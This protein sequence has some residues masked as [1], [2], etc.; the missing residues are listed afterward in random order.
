MRSGTVGVSESKHTPTTM[1][2]TNWNWT[3]TCEHCK[4][5][6]CQSENEHGADGM[7]LIKNVFENSTSQWKTSKRIVRAIEYGSARIGEQLLV[8]P[9]NPMQTADMHAAQCIEPCVRVNRTYKLL[10]RMRRVRATT[11]ESKLT[12]VPLCCCCCCGLC[13]F[14][15][16][17]REIPLYFC[18]NFICSRRSP[19]LYV[20][21]ESIWCVAVYVFIF[22]LPFFL[23]G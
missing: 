14:V 15:S 17:W 11:Q 5:L 9:C 12:F 1:L 7:N 22:F 18:G 16:Q 4:R 2:W 3:A 6:S 13:D 10:V 21:F 20:R 23:L 8:L 19:L